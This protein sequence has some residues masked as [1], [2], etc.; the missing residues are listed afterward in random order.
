VGGAR[1]ERGAT[2]ADPI[3]DDPHFGLRPYGIA[4]LIYTSDVIVWDNIRVFKSGKD[5]RIGTEFGLQME[6]KYGDLFGLNLQGV[7]YILRE[8]FRK[9]FSAAVRKHLFGE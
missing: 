5:L 3:L 9:E 4:N 2:L 7:E 6:K 1:F 8:F